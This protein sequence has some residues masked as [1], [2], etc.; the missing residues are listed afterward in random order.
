MNVQ[1]LMQQA[2]KMQKQLQ[3]TQKKL[4]TE[5]FK[6]RAGGEAIEVLMDGTYKMKSIKIDPNII[7][8]NDV[9]MLEDLIVT[10]CN[11]CKNRV[12]NENQSNL[13]KI[14]GNMNMSSA[15]SSMLS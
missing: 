5:E 14:T 4:K 8:I 15:L 9:E 13:G 10:A 7:D 6:G 12:D 3:E 11:D 1:Q 2:Q